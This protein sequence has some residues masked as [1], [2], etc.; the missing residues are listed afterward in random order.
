M[1][2]FKKIKVEAQARSELASAM[3][4]NH[5]IIAVV[6]PK[7]SISNSNDVLKI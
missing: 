1:L 5:Y 3:H 6:V 2:L 4:E 7:P